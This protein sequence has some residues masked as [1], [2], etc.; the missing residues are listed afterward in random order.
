MPLA[1]SAFRFAKKKMRTS[2]KSGHFLVAAI[3]GDIQQL[4]SQNTVN[5]TFLFNYA[6]FLLF[7][8]ARLTF[9]HA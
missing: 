7:T 1:D 9:F 5:L 2:L 3:I 4:L 8:T 6:F